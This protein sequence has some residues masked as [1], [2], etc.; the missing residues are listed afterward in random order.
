M[1]QWR[2]QTRR[3]G[4]QSNM[5]RQKGLHLLKYQR[6]S[7]TLVGCHT[8]V[9]TFCRPKS[10]Y[11]CWSKYGIFQGISTVWKRFISLIQKIF[12][13]GLEQSASCFTSYTYIV[14]LQNVVGYKTMLR[15]SVCQVKNSVW[16]A[17]PTWLEVERFFLDLQVTTHAR[18]TIGLK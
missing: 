12:E 14:F 1:P 5:G 18:P 17:F 13:T 7:A 11:F 3:L 2:I 9:V 10:V 6:L 16:N 4:G 8:K 15:T